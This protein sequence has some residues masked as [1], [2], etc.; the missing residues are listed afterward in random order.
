MKYTLKNVKL[1]NDMSDETQCFSAAIYCDGRK[2]GAVQNHGTGGSHEY[3]F[4]RHEDGE[5]LNKFAQSLPHE[6]DF[7]ITDQ[8][9]D[10]LLLEWDTTRQLKRWCKKETLFRLKGDQEG[11]WRRI[12]HT[13]DPAV[14][15]FIASKYGDQV[16]EIAN[17][18]LEA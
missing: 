9:I 8:Y 14:K 3:W 17:E 5:A 12:L 10:K 6:F 15:Q 13:Y 18:R 4:P 7:D 1:Q 16:E 2:I 11:A